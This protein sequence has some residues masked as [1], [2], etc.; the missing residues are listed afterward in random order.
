[1]VHGPLMPRASLL[2]QGVASAAN[3]PRCCMVLRLPADLEEHER[4]PQPRKVCHRAHEG[5]TI[6]TNS[7]Q[8]ELGWLP[9]PRS[10][11]TPRA[12][13]ASN[14]FRDLRT[15]GCARWSSAKGYG[16]IDGRSNL[17]QRPLDLASLGPRHPM[18]CSL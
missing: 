11:R 14:N 2:P 4:R 13:I 8:L 5:S 10:D 16:E 6:H 1:M 17:Q 15:A 7:D 18:A 12:C 3:R 9:V